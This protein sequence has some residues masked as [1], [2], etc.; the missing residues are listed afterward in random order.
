M[1][2][3]AGMSRKPRFV[4]EIFLYY[5]EEPLFIAHMQT[6]VESVYISLSTKITWRRN[7]RGALLESVYICWSAKII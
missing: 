4:Q 2:Y 7:V 3:S 1:G 5:K 6:A